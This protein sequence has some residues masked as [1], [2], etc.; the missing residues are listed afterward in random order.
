MKRFFSLFLLLAFF[1]GAT[2]QNT[3]TLFLWPG[4]VPGENA[5]KQAAVLSDN[6]SRNVTRLAK[7]TNP[8]LLA[9]KPENGKE[10]ACMI[11]C[12]GGGY[13]HLALDIEGTEIAAW[14]N[15]LGIAAWVLQYRVPGNPDGA[16]QD[17][18][19]AMRLVK[20]QN[21]GK[22]V[23]V[24]G[25]SAGGSLSA[26]AATRFNQNTYPYTDAA[27]SILPRPDFVA[28]LYPAYLDQGENRTL[29]PELTLSEK[30]P[31]MFLFGTAD[32]KL[33]NSSLVMAQ[34][35]RDN[36]IPVELHILPFGG[37]GYGK[38]SG[39]IAAET[40][41]ALLKNWLNSQLTNR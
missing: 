39:N 1:G 24:M 5:P 10:K 20:Q 11:V 13:H 29:T 31:P 32:D 22:K 33:C 16:L 38:R 6:T 18:Q 40:W 9:F 36:G 30:T 4:Q 37:H 2:A 8:L 23:G 15:T 28:L 17:I 35:L 19:R 7:V 3:D 41:P 21:P 12:P 34:A 25:F 26:R 27:D 14:L